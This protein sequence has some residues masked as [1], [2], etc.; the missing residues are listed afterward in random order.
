MKFTRNK[1]FMLLIA[2]AAAL[3][4]AGGIAVAATFTTA[5]A[6]GGFGKGGSGDGASLAARIAEKL[7]DALELDEDITETQVQT[8]LNGVT[9]D[10]QEEILQARLDD[11][12]V[13]DATKTE[14]MDWFD[15][16]PYADLVRFRT[17]GLATSDN[18]SSFLERLVE[19]E[20]ITQAQSDGIQ[21][22][23]DERPD[24]PEGLERSGRGRHGG[25]AGTFFRGRH[26]RGG[27]GPGSFFRGRFGRGGDGPGSLYHGRHGRGGNGDADTF[28][29]GR[30]G[31]GSTQAT[32]SSL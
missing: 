13:E 9:A 2:G 7:N 30:N 25:G 22:W 21:G 18:A 12:E 23:Y 5:H 24:L 8:A 28:F 11:L 4:I 19:N 20:K 16:Y 14:I 10:R 1:I 32:G 3:G 6:H 27:D 26:G 15:D 17:I 29:R 31:G